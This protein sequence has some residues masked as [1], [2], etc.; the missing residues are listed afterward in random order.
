MLGSGLPVIPRIWVCRAAASEFRSPG[1]PGVAERGPVAPRLAPFRLTLMVSVL[2]T[3]RPE[4][5][6][7]AALA[8]PVWAGLWPEPPEPVVATVIN[9]DAA[10]TVV[11]A[12]LGWAAS[13]TRLRYTSLAITVVVTPLTAIS[14][15]VRLN[16]EVG[17]EVP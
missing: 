14:V 16:C 12:S 8:V 17:S 3:P 6:A 10:L 4:K 13:M 9:W 1:L 11:A 15:T 5:V 7:M 2:T